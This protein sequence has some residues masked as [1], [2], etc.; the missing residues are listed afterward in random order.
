MLPLFSRVRFSPDSS[1]G[2]V[3]VHISAV[4]LAKKIRK[5]DALVV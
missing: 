3:G 1:H 2:A 4:R 5:I